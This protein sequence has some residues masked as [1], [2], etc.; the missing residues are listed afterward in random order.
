[1][2]HSGERWEGGEWCMVVN[3]ERVVNGGRVVN[4]AWW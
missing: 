2:M 3:G 4:D 1:M